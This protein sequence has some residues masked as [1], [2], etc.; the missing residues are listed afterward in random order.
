MKLYVGNL[1]YSIS[2]DELKDLFGQFG[3]VRSV[4]IITDRQSGRSKGFGFVEMSSQ[5]EGQKA[6]EA[7][8]RTT[9]HN[10]Q[11]VVNEATTKPKKS[12]QKRDPR[13]W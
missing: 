6:I 13:R 4:K 3:E 7:M 11:M 8:N 10:R 12:F 5:S 9:I 2:E 1:A